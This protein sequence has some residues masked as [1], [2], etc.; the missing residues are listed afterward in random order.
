MQTR[1]LLALF[2]AGW[3]CGGCSPGGGSSDSDSDPSPSPGTSPPVTP[4]QPE[5]DLDVDSDRDGT[6]ENNSDDDASEHFWSATSGAVFYLNIDDDDNDGLPDNSGSFVT[7]SED[8]FDLARI[9]VRKFDAAPSDG[10]AKILASP[11]NRSRLFRNGGSTWSLLS[12]TG[13]SFPLP[14]ADIIAGEIELGIEAT[15]R[16][17]STWNGEIVLTLEI[18]DGGGSLIGADLVRLRCA[19]LILDHNLLPVETLHVVD[20][21]SSNASFRSDL[22][23]AATAGG[24]THYAVPGNAYLNDRWIQDSSERGFVLLP[25]DTGPRRRVDSVL[26]C[27]RNRPIDNWGEQYLFGAD[28]DFH[29]EF[30][31]NSQSINYGGNLEIAPP[32]S[33]YPW[34]R[35]VVGGGS[36]YTI[37]GGTWNNLHMDQ[38]YRTFL[39]ALDVQGPHLE[40]SSEWLAVGHVDE[41][42]SFVKAPS[43]PKGWIIALASPA[44][45]KQIL[46]N[47]QTSGGGSLKIFENRGSWETTV[48]QVLN[49]SALMT[50]NQE[51]Q[52]RIDA[53]RAQYKTAFGLS[54]SEVIDVPVLFEDVGSGEAAA[55]NPG[56]ANMVVL[57][58]ANGTTRLVVPDPEG[59]HDPTDAWADATKTAL[60][61]FGTGANPVNVIFTDVFNAYHQNL[62][63]AHCGINTIRTPPAEDW[64]DD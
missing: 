21:G 41:F 15:S 48:D 20:L 23:A 40:V 42:T 64:W 60:E 55:Y 8:A 51:A 12:G 27:A 14:I 59:P 39:D 7:G 49:D 18:R 32:H 35:I 2:L 4:P 45:A 46:E 52:Q 10:T 29:F 58:F 56:V 31:S 5:V 30:G 57:A 19:P 17:D 13:S 26:Q 53:I 54:N 28:Q 9:V 1:A 24:F 37:G 16:A 50:Y 11:A 36:S 61:V 63:E 62:G 34:G 44:L 22:Q 3:I 33:G 25:T 38:A 6:V 43:S 47:V